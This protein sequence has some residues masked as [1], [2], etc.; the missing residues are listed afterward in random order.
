MTLHACRARLIAI[1]VE[2]SEDMVL[3]HIPGRIFDHRPPRCF[4][5]SEELC[6]QTAGHPAVKLLDEVVDNG[7]DA[8]ASLEMS[9]RWQDYG[10]PLFK[11]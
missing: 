3:G 9:D 6:A 4:H 5:N 1:A 11:K 2:T 8:T 7:T 10:L